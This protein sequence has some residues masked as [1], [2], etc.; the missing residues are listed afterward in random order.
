[1]SSSLITELPLLC[2]RRQDVNRAV[3]EADLQ[4]ANVVLMLEDFYLLREEGCAFLSF[5]LWVWN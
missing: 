1:M 4:N 2:W 3:E 5:S